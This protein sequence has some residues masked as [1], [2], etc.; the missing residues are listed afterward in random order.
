MN[1]RTCGAALSKY[2]TVCPE[3]GARNQPPAGDARS[4]SPNRSRKNARVIKRLKRLALIAGIAMTVLLCAATLLYIRFGPGLSAGK[5]TA[6]RSAAA[7]PTEFIEAI[8]VPANVSSEAQTAYWE[9][10][11]QPFIEQLIRQE[12]SNEN[13]SVGVC[14]SLVDLN[15]DGVPELLNY[16]NVCI[17]ENSA[18]AEKYEDDDICYID[19][20]YIKDSQVEK[21]GQA[22]S[23][24]QNS[25]YYGPTFDLYYDLITQSF[26]Y[27]STGEYGNEGYDYQYIY[28]EYSGILWSGQSRKAPSLQ[29]LYLCKTSSDIEYFVQQ[30]EQKYVSFD[31]DVNVYSTL[32]HQGEFILT[33]G[34]ALDSIYS[35]IDYGRFIPVF[36]GLCWYATEDY[37][38]YFDFPLTDAVAPNDVSNLTYSDMAQGVF[39]T[40]LDNK[41]GNAVCA[42][43]AMN[44][45]A[46]NGTCEVYY[47]VGSPYYHLEYDCPMLASAINDTNCDTLNFK[48]YCKYKPCP[49]CIGSQN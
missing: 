42:N 43:T 21:L 48:L 25:D 27:I 37:Q 36:Q 9:K 11:Y 31:P 44:L 38:N 28:Y 2:D 7:G 14:M 19:V 45:F 22:L 12:Y 17:D 47:A 4:S 41:I 30:N 15:F 49:E 10:I 40:Y 8:S 35:I 46:N 23:D 18:D 3:C 26:C 20:Y 5:A 13:L 39:E 32:Q 33:N 1:C 34:N 24:Y 6:A 29:Q 16:Y